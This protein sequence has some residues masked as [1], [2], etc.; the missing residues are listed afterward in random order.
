MEKVNLQYQNENA[1]VV[2]GFLK[3]LQ[4][5]MRNLMFLSN[6]KRTQLVDAMW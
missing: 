5:F 1:M 6:F 2:Y 3:I 4:L